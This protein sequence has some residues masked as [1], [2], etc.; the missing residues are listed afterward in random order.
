[1]KQ[2]IIFFLPLLFCASCG[3]QKQINRATA[4]HNEIQALRDLNKDKMEKG[5]QSQEIGESIDSTYVKMQTE[6]NDLKEKVRKNPTD[7]AQLKKLKKKSES[8]QTTI[9]TFLK[10]YKIETFRSF[11]ASRF[12]KSGEYNINLEDAAIILNDLNPLIDK[13]IHIIEED[14][15]VNIEVIIGVY[16]YTDEQEVGINGPLYKTLANALNKSK[17]TQEELNQKLSEFRA[18]SLSDLIQQSVEKRKTEEANKNHIFYNINWLGRGFTKLP[19]KG[20]SAKKVD[21]K[22]RVVTVIWGVK[23]ILIDA[24]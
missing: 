11:E 18:K 7:L 8:Y 13:I 16:G 10:L 1:M 17:P 2:Y 12:F 5:T 3:T 9:E 24:N 23:P 15:A 20:M 14:K 4:V 21:E 19:F 22:R 6:I